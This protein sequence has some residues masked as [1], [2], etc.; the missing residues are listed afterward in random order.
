[1][2]QTVE[3][4][5]QYFP[6]FL[7]EHPILLSAYQPL[8]NHHFFLLIQQHTAGSSLHASFE[9]LEQLLKIKRFF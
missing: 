5:G 3:A 8:L 9:N 4:A 6:N 2:E 7:K 1:M